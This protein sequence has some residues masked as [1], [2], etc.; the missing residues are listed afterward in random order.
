[1]NSNVRPTGM[2]PCPSHIAGG[3]V[4]CYTPIDSRHR[5]TGNTRQIV[6][7]QVLGTAAGLAICQHADDEGF[8]LYGCDQHWNPLSD[9]W[10]ASLVEAQSQ[11]EF[12]YIGSR[13]T[14]LPFE[15]SAHE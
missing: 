6:N 11:A 5:H 10:H 3:R 14:W 7:G 15:P 1:V 2:H 8:Y 13:E 4:V 12:E 9:T